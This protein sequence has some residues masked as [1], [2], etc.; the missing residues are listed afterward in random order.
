MRVIAKSSNFR[1]RLAWNFQAL[2]A[3]HQLFSKIIILRIIFLTAQI[4]L[5]SCRE[6]YLLMLRQMIVAELKKILSKSH[7]CLAPGFRKNSWDTCNEQI[8]WNPDFSNLQ[9]KRKLVREIGSSKYRG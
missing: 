9:G 1:T 4:F 5:E 2:S 7:S 3:T 8:Q 6:V